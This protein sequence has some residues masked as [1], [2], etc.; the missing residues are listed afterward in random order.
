[1]SKLCMQMVMTPSWMISLNGRISSRLAPKA[2]ADVGSSEQTI[3][4]ELLSR[5]EIRTPRSTSGVTTE[6]ASDAL[7]DQVQ[8]PGWLYET[9]RMNELLTSFS[10][11]EDIST[12]GSLETYGYFGTS[13]SLAGADLHGNQPNTSYGSATRGQNG[14]PSLEVTDTSVSIPDFQCGRSILMPFRVPSPT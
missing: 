10:Q 7:D 11:G 1:M 9:H 4:K 3:T 5:E 14:P 12:T 2:C 8:E 13:N 6:P